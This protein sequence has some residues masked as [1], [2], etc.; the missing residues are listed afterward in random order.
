MLRIR[1]PDGDSPRDVLRDNG[2]RVAGKSERPPIRAD[3]LDPA[4]VEHLAVANP[5]ACGLGVDTVELGSIFDLAAIRQAHAYALDL[6]FGRF[7]QIF[8]SQ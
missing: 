3:S 7:A 8:P 6:W 4:R 5:A 2:L 1:H